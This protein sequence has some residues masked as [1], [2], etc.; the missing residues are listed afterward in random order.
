MIK[1][2]MFT[3]STQ[4]WEPLEAIEKLAA[5]G[6]DGVELRMREP[7]PN[8][9]PPIDIGADELISRA[10][11]IKAKAADCGV[12][13]PSLA[14]YVRNTDM[15]ASI[16]ALEACAAIGAKCVRIGAGGYGIDD[17]AWQATLDAKAR[18]ALLAEKAAELG[19]KAVME[20]HHGTINPTT[21][22][23]RFILEGIDPAHA[24][25]MWD[26]ANQGREGLDRYH[27]AVSMAGPYLAEVHV[28]N[29][30]YTSSIEEDGRTDWKAGWAPLKDGMVNWPQVVNILKKA[31]YDG[32]LIFEYLGGKQLPDQQFKDDLAWFRE[33]VAC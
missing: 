24:G 11:E 22:A 33:L 29:V 16:K 6:F 12:E 7:T 15:D 23:S 21:L 19:V 13:L 30:L 17:D 5:L 1:L 27:M 20:T 8:G 26:P 4:D 10:D 31:D 3:V 2:G 32:W 25:I 9:N 14:S 28:K 18:Y